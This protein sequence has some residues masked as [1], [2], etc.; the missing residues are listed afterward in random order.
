MRLCRE[1]LLLVPLGSLLCVE[2]TLSL[3]GGKARTFCPLIKIGTLMAYFVHVIMVCQVLRTQKSPLS[4]PPERAASLPS[5]Q[6]LPD[7]QRTDRR[8]TNRIYPVELRHY[9]SRPGRIRPGQRGQRSRIQMKAANLKIS[10]P[11][12]RFGTFGIVSEMEP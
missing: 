5:L 9:Q 7:Q 11:S 1:F 2:T 10:R 4:R 8:R 3:I 12:K 6:E